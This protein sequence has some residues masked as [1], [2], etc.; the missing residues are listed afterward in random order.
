MAVHEP[1]IIVQFMT[2]VEDFTPIKPITGKGNSFED[3]MFLCGMFG[4]NQEQ[5]LMLA[6]I[7]LAYALLIAK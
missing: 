2:L 7:G 5:V 6:S 1:S 3:G 4:L